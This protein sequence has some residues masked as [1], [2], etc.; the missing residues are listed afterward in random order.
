[1]SCHLPVQNRACTLAS[2]QWK[3]MQLR[4]TRFMYQNRQSYS[5][6]E[7]NTTWR[8]VTLCRQGKEGKRVQYPLRKPGAELSPGRA[9]SRAVPAP[10]PWGSLL[11][12]FPTAAP[13]QP[14]D[15]KHGFLPPRTNTGKGFV[16]D[17]FPSCSWGSTATF[18]PLLMDW[19]LP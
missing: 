6:R 9:Q 13:P 8:A 5:S 2:M 12:A 4:S 7:M 1:M 16:S 17:S 10:L 15:A 14:R 3:S 18:Y 19:Q 11:P